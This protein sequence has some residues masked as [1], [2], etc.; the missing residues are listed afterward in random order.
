MNRP[1]Y[2]ENPM[3]CLRDLVADAVHAKLNRLKRE[4]DEAD[5]K[6]QIARAE[7]ND[8][9]TLSEAGVFGDI[10]V[11]LITGDSECW[12][13]VCRRVKDLDDGEQWGP[14]TCRVH[15]HYADR[16][17]FD[18]HLVSKIFPDFNPTNGIREG[19]ERHKAGQ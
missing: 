6:A 19:L 13:E 11:N 18:L 5:R 1:K 4:A 10:D 14:T 3:A 12:A 9:L 17:D 16:E 15:A 7:L 2:T 8:A